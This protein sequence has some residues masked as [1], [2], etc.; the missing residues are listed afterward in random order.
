MPISSNSHSSREECACARP[1][2]VTQWRHQLL[3][4]ACPV[5]SCSAICLALGSRGRLGTLSTMKHFTIH[6]IISHWIVCFSC[7]PLGLLDL[8]VPVLQVRIQPGTRGNW[9]LHQSFFPSVSCKCCTGCSLCTQLS[10]RGIVNP[11]SPSESTP[12]QSTSIPLVG[13]CALF[14]IVLIAPDNC[15][16]PCAIFC[17]PRN[18][19]SSEGTGLNTQSIHLLLQCSASSFFLGPRGT[20]CDFSTNTTN[21]FHTRSEIH[22]RAPHSLITRG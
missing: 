9:A 14:S 8:G 12:T 11:S 17:C 22:Q 5:N 2:D 7:S 19:V 1:F 10:N 15:A 4:T 3:S 13:A 18:S 20:T 6:R 21:E 16:R